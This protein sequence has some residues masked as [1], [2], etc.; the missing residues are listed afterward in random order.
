[1]LQP[2]LELREKQPLP[3]SNTKNLDSCVVRPHDSWQY[4]ILAD[5]HIFKDIIPPP[6]SL[7][8][9]LMFRQD[10][11]RELLED[12]PALG[13]MS[14]SPPWLPTQNWVPP[15]V[16]EPPM[17]YVYEEMKPPKKSRSSNG[18]D[19]VN[20]A[21]SSN[22]KR[23][24]KKATNG[25]VADETPPTDVVMTDSS[26]QHRSDSASQNHRRSGR[27]GSSSVSAS[28]PPPAT[29]GQTP[30]GPSRSETP[31]F[32]REDSMDSMSHQAPVDYPPTA[33]SPPYHGQDDP[34]WTGPSQFT[35]PASGFLRGSIIPQ[36]RS[37]QNPGRTIYSQS[38]P[39]DR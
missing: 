3:R 30:A 32:S 15:P 4:H 34:E 37:S 2:L 1:M 11:E 17:E 22:S 24:S 10:K 19:K 33:H 6:V 39:P 23:T 21:A 26:S 14:S 27:N 38:N 31:S 8:D 29:N 5:W 35:G 7:A 28:I 18:K 13:P 36:S 20:G 16:E 9:A 12:N 25:H